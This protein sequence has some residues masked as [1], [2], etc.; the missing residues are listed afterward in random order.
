MEDR[1]YVP[2]QLIIRDKMNT[3]AVMSC[4]LAITNILNIASLLKFIIFNFDNVIMI[5]GQLVYVE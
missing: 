4:F 2:T 3:L 5:K 1:K